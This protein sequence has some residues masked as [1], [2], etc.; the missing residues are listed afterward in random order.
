MCSHITEA[1]SGPPVRS[2]T[3]HIGVRYQH[4]MYRMCLRLGYTA[5]LAL[6]T[7][8]LQVS[9]QLTFLNRFCELHLSHVILKHHNHINGGY[10]TKNTPR[11]SCLPLTLSVIRGVL[12]TFR[13]NTRPRET[14][15]QESPLFQLCMLDRSEWF[16]TYSLRDKTRGLPPP[17]RDFPCIHASYI[18]SGAVFAE[19]SK[20]SLNGNN[21]FSSN[22]AADRGGKPNRELV[23]VALMLTGSVQNQSQQHDSR[24]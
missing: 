23:D 15:S 10:L 2:Y 17:K 1:T 12:S 11:S 6:V 4:V 16:T 8:S 5:S 9:L 3:D 21:L 22:R 7:P 14:R 20:V 19:F 18:P 24:S 13:R